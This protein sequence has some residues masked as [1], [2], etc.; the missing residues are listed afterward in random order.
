MIKINLRDYYPI[1]TQNHYIEVEDII[2]VTL[3]A[4]ERRNIAYQKRVNRHRAYYS[5][6][7]NDGIENDII[8]IVQTPPEIYEKTLANQTLYTAM[9]VL[10]GKQF[11]RIYAHYFLGLRKQ[12]I[13]KAEGVDESSVR[14]S[15]ETGLKRM[16]MFIRNL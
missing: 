1:Y 8:C 9:N 13:A 16:A 5:L 10:S 7:R 15:I 14:K 12:A 11:R 4:F 2:A 6:E 3:K